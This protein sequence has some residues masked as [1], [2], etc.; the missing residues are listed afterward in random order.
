M[1]FGTVG[2]GSNEDAVEMVDLDVIGI[3]EVLQSFRGVDDMFQPSFFMEHLDPVISLIANQDVVV[4]IHCDSSGCVELTR[5][6]TKVSK[7]EQ[8]LTFLGQD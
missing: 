4:M 5:T 2:P 6:V 1:E 7:P 8:F 3:V